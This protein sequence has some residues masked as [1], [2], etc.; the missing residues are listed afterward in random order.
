MNI[1]VVDIDPRVSAKQL[2]DKH[3]VKM[4]LESCQ[5]LCSQFPNGLAPYKRSYYNH[6]CSVWVRKSKQNYEWLLNHCDELILEYK[7]RYNNKSHKS[8]STLQFCKDY[9][10]E[11]N[12]P[13]VGLTKQPICMP[14]EVKK[15]NDV[16]ES[17]RNYYKVVK[18]SFAKWKLGNIPEWYLQ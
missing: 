10:Y 16:V 7:K 3:V 12:L 13:D 9:Y 14:I 2:C 15:E 11:L 1:F 5:M 17:Y 6:P 18:S 4:I 8:E